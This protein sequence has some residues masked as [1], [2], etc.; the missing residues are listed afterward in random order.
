MPLLAGTEHPISIFF[1]RIG[2]DP[3]IEACPYQVR[4]TT[5]SSRTAAESPV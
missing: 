4:S 5:Y 2:H 3:P 1:N